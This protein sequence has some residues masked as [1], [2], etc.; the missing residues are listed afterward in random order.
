MELNSSNT[1]YIECKYSNNTKVAYIASKKV[2]GNA[3]KRN[4]AKR[5]LRSLVRENSSIIPNNYLMLFIAS[6]KAYNTEYQLLKNDFLHCIN[7]I[8]KF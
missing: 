1:G 4:R 3:V 2:V 5:R 8:S 6:A 7:K